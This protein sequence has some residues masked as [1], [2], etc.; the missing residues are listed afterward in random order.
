ME[1]SKFLST[2]ITMHQNKLLTKISSSSKISSVPQGTN[3]VVERSSSRVSSHYQS[4]SIKIFIHDNDNT[5]EQSF[6]RMSEI[7]ETRIVKRLIESDQYFLSRIP[8]G[9]NPVVM[10]TRE[11]ERDQGRGESS[12]QFWQ[13][14]L[15]RPSK[16]EPCGHPLLQTSLD[17]HTCAHKPCNCSSCAPKES[18]IRL[19]LEVKGSG[20]RKKVAVMGFLDL[21]WIS[22]FQKKSRPVDL[23]TK[24][25]RHQL[26]NLPTLAGA[27]DFTD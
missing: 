20:S 17:P 6:L 8:R 21:S 24:G 4:S 2:I 10:Q 27:S 25:N 5:L 7:V 26:D 23:L 3:P 15:N 14:I 1:T 18:A 11:E 16:N 19:E 12:G 9:T 13:L 22:T